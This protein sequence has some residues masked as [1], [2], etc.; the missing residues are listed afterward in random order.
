MPAC[1]TDWHLAQRRAAQHLRRGSSMV[2]VLFI[3]LVLGTSVVSLLNNLGNEIMVN[4]TR[5]KRVKQ[6]W[7][8]DAGLEIG[9]G[10]LRIKT[11]RQSWESGL[12]NA[13]GLGTPTINGASV[14]TKLTNGSTPYSSD[15]PIARIESTATNG[16]TVVTVY[17]DV[18]E[19]SASDFSQWWSFMSLKGTAGA[20]W[21]TPA[22][23]AVQPNKGKVFIDMQGRIEFT[24]GL[25]F[26]PPPAGV[27]GPYFE[28]GIVMGSAFNSNNMQ[29]TYWT[30]SS[31]LPDAQAVSGGLRYQLQ[32]EELPT[33]D[34]NVLQNIQAMTSGLVTLTAPT[35]AH[36]T[37]IR[38]RGSTFEYRYV[39]DPYNCS[40]S[41]HVANPAYV[42]W[43]SGGALPC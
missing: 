39:T 11:N 28:G 27:S 17:Q 20:W 43:T 1:A 4:A 2:Y 18:K 40:H 8:A 34:G 37:Q 14:T 32:G 22:K 25:E 12:F 21:N 5:N 24:N 31:G 7:A 9:R 30:N 33:L 41:W 16:D 26:L 3:V 29:L 6:M 23:L 35:T 42:S 10:R 38:I 19:S 36:T 15:Y 13:G